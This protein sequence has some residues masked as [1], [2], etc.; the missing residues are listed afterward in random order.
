MWFPALQFYAQPQNFFLHHLPKVP[1]R[2]L[3]CFQLHSQSSEIPTSYH[4]RFLQQI[5]Y[6]TYY[7]HGCHFCLLNSRN[8][9]KQN[10]RLCIYPY[11]FSLLYAVMFANFLFPSLLQL[12][13]SGGGSLLQLFCWQTHIKI[14]LG[15]FLAWFS[16]LIKFKTQ[17][18]KKHWQNRGAEGV[19]QGWGIWGSCSSPGKLQHFARACFQHKPA[20]NYPRAE[21]R[22]H[23]AVLWRTGIQKT[24]QAKSDLLCRSRVSVVEGLNCF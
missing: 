19:F 5:W 8:K 22:T 9:A 11:R 7:W 18:L 16:F 15:F 3:C 12:S 6:F 24:D 13:A 17:L 1:Y 14:G 10:I 23:W 20:G 21:A 2:D 4:L